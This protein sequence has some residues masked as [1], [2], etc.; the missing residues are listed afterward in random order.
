V[1]KSVCV[2]VCEVTILNLF[3]IVHVLYIF[4]ARVRFSGT[5]SAKLALE[6]ANESVGGSIKVEDVEVNCSVLG[7]EHYCCTI[8]V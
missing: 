7:G 4:Q 8:F 2:R 5:D 1:F 6:K 3:V